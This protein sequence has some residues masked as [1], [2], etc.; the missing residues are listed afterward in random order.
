MD[1][2]KTVGAVVLSVA[3]LVLL[4]VAGWAVISR[5]DAAPVLVTGSDGKVTVVD[6]YVR[7]KDFFTLVL[8]LFTTLAAF[9]LGGQAQSKR[10]DDEK[11]RADEA[12]AQRS[13]ADQRSAALMAT[14]D[15][16][17]QQRARAAAPVAF[18]D[19]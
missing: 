13:L 3:L 18:N 6:T 7:A 5:L 4:A 9:W 15:V 12:I 1:T 2:F 10:A 8:P 16:D 17:A 19:V 11:Q 14:A